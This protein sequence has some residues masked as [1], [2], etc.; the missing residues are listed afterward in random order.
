MPTV[1]QAS[2]VLEWSCFWLALQPQDPTVHSLS[3]LSLNVSSSVKTVTEVTEWLKRLR[4]KMLQWYQ[5]GDK[6]V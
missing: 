5:E 4:I 3:Q 1:K 2:T 6:I